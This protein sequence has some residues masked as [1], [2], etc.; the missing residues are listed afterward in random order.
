MGPGSGA[1]LG[2]AGLDVSAVASLCASMNGLAAQ[3]RGEHERR[4]RVAGMMWGVRPPAISLGSLPALRSADGG[5]N[6]GFF[7]AVQRITIGPAGAAT[8][9]VT[10][11]RGTSSADV[12]PQNA[13]N[14]FTFA[15]VGQFAPWHPGG[16]GLILMPD[17][18]LIF[19]GTITGANP[20]A[21]VEVHQGRIDLLPDYLL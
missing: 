21:N 6:T 18:S 13:L 7:W 9:L 4:R 16:R 19:A 17:E 20:I 12:Q 2:G 1:G 11:Y 5:P 15:A 14:S 10:V 3:L 8:D